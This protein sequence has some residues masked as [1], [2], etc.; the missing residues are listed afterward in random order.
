MLLDDLLLQ[1]RTCML[2]S[3]SIFGVVVLG[4]QKKSGGQNGLNY[5]GYVTLFLTTFANM[6]MKIEPIISS[7]NSSD[8]N[9]SEN[10]V[11]IVQSTFLQIVFIASLGSM[12]YSFWN[13]LG[14]ARKDEMVGAYNIMKSLVST[15]NVRSRDSSS[16]DLY[17]LESQ[18]KTATNIILSDPDANPY[19]RLEGDP[20][21]K[22]TDLSCGRSL[23][24]ALNKTGNAIA[25]TTNIFASYGSV[26]TLLSVLWKSHSA[27]PISSSTS[28]FFAAGSF[29]ISFCAAYQFYLYRCRD[30]SRN[31]SKL[32]QYISE[33][34]G[35]NSSFIFSMII[36]ISAVLNY[37]FNN[38]Y[39]GVH[40][41]QKGLEGIISL[42]HKSNSE[43]GSVVP[44]SGYLAWGVLNSLF[45]VIITVS[46]TQEAMGIT[47]KIQSLCTS[48]AKRLRN[49]GC[50]D[51]IELT[52]LLTTCLASQFTGTFSSIKSAEIIHFKQSS[53][54]A[55]WVTITYTV[56]ILTQLASLLYDLSKAHF[57]NMEKLTKK[58]NTILHNLMINQNPTR[59]PDYAMDRHHVDLSNKGRHALLKPINSQIP[60]RDE[61]QTPDAE[62]DFRAQ[63]ESLFK[64]AL[65]NEPSAQEVRKL[66]QDIWDNNSADN[67]SGK[68]LRVKTRVLLQWIVLLSLSAQGKLTDDETR[69]SHATMSV[70]DYIHHLFNEY[71]N[72][73]S[74]EPTSKTKESKAWVSRDLKV[75]LFEPSQKRHESSSSKYHLTQGSQKS[76]LQGKYDH[77]YH[78]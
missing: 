5:I 21:S 68:N 10:N 58:L 40:Q 77:K 11:D 70:P 15:P 30:N 22:P 72:W 46:N 7:T 26:Y 63:L 38:Y 53:I 16:E 57:P 8:A 45:G 2:A 41:T 25:L 61:K 73:E 33:Q 47:S 3:N 59:L 49:Q 4:K 75:H 34:R 36:L 20:L 64:T 18:Q 37:G 43:S 35:F 23:L 27:S 52:F 67:P 44:G 69:T 12:V 24:T 13:R 60:S 6:A 51:K 9:H 66:H 42:F 76:A 19:V 55:A 32:R 65:I 28:H 71:D 31:I 62:D 74:G 54:Q 17:D 39:R 48:I 56:S 1:S 78:P 29:L 14:K 50:C